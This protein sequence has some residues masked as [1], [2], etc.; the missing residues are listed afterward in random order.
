MSTDSEQIEQRVKAALDALGV[1][2]EILPCDPEVA[3]TQAFC[4]RYGVSLSESANAIVVATKKERRQY[5][6]CLV[7]ATT[8]LDVN[9]AVRRLMGSKKLSFASAEQT[10]AVT[11]MM[12]GG[13]TPFGL[14]RDLPLFIDRRVMECE[15]V[16]I[17]GGS[18]SCKIRLS[19]KAFEQLPQA[20]IVDGLATISQ[21]F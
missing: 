17:G 12:V 4:E 7:L 11:G 10:A 19:P 20:Q 1:S 18:R 9:H 5:S 6:A 16:V 15:S 8:R 13:V 3:D 21:K 2:Y 14:P